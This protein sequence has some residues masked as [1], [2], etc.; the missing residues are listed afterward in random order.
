MDA[1]N[2]KNFM[3]NDFILRLRL[4]KEEAFRKNEEKKIKER[5]ETKLR[6]ELNKKVREGNEQKC[7]KNQTTG[8]AFKEN[9]DPNKDCSRQIPV[10]TKRIC[11]T[12]QAE[13]KDKIKTV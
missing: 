12:S 6:R 3:P 13:N 10:E 8:T 1:P 11:L 7:N 2:K 9:T 4:A 5:E